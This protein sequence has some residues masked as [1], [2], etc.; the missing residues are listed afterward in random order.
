VGANARPLAG[1]RVLDAAAAPGGKTTHLA[2]LGAQV[3]ATDVRPGRMR[4]IAE[5][6]ARL[7]VAERVLPLA[8][9]ALAPPFPHGSFDAVLLDAPCSGLGVVRRRPELRWRREPGDPARLGELQGSLL[10]ALAP[11]VR[12]GGVLCYGACT[13]TRAET[14]D[15]VRDFLA[16][17]GDRFGPLDPAEALR[18]AG[19]ALPGAPVTLLDPDRDGTDGFAISLLRRTS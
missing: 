10:G 8:A 9:D 12:P 11:L 7:H 16:I 6:A 15:V 1:L 18:G 19:R 3:V 5:T 17:E 14:S 2:A 4:L 13:W